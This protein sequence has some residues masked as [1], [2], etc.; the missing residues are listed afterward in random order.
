MEDNPCRCDSCGGDFCHPE[1]GL[2]G[3]GCDGKKHK[4][5]DRCFFEHHTEVDDWPTK[6]ELCDE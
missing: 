3:V 2:V 1:D 6:E 4:I 5:C